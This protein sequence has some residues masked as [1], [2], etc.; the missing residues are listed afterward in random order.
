M[1]LTHFKQ[2]TSH[3]PAC[4][5]TDKLRLTQ[6]DLPV[7]SLC[8]ITWIHGEQTRT[9]LQ[10]WL[11]KPWGIEDNNHIFPT[12]ALFTRLKNHHQQPEHVCACFSQEHVVTLSTQLI[13]KYLPI[14]ARGRANGMKWHVVSSFLEIHANTREKVCESW[15]WQ[16]VISNQT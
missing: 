4:Q 7:R 1:K 14:A 3:R 11:W 15:P 12:N 8:F 9:L 13:I 5:L 10:Y 16:L 2:Q 6:T